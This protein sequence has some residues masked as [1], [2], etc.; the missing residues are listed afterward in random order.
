MVSGQC[1]LERQRCLN[2]P[3]FLWYWLCHSKY[4]AVADFFQWADRFHF[5]DR[6]YDWALPVTE[7]HLCY[8][9]CLRIWG[10][11]LLLF[12]SILE[13]HRNYRHIGSIEKNKLANLSGTKFSHHFCAS[14]SD[15]TTRCRDSWSSIEY[16]GRAGKS[17]I[18]DEQYR[19]HSNNCCSVANYL[20][21]SETV[22]IYTWRN[23]RLLSPCKK[24]S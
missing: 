14:F 2:R 20:S 22:C 9:G 11:F 23:A 8:Y 3:G 19:Y 21:D 7:K 1:F 16:S 10:L 17:F 18:P 6:H 4:Q 24:Y 13:Y 5:C 12:G 15:Y